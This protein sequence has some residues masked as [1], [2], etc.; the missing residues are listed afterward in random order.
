MHICNTYGSPMALLRALQ[1]NGP[2]GATV[3]GGDWRALNLPLELAAAN[4]CSDPRLIEGVAMKRN[5]AAFGVERCWAVPHE[6][7]NLR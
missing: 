4:P 3:T 6:N 2:V 1:S 5:K 7:V